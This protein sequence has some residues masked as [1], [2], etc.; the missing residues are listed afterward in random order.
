MTEPPLTPRGWL[1]VLTAVN[2][3]IVQI[4]GL[5]SAHTGACVQF[6][7]QEEVSRT[8]EGKQGSTR[9]QAAIDTGSKCV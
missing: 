8:V 2:K 3:G 6:F 7:A 9:D 1:G 5:A 4:D